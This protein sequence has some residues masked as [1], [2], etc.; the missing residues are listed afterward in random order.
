MVHS[1][2]TSADHFNGLLENYQQ[3]VQSVSMTP[4]AEQ[5]AVVTESLF[6]FRSIGAIS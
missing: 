4:L 6:T 1:A 3:K 5:M 2:L